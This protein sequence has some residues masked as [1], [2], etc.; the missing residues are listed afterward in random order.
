M[1]EGF[2]FKSF[3]ESFE[4]EFFR[5]LKGFIN[6]KGKKLLVLGFDEFGYVLD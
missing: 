5:K 4:Y 6:F 2:F 3:D 1:V